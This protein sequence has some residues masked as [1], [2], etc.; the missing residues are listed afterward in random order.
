MGTRDSVPH[1]SLV[2]ATDESQ[3]IY[4]CEFVH[5]MNI[6]NNKSNTNPITDERHGEKRMEH[7]AA[8]RG[9]NK[10]RKPT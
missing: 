5:T 4:V 9:S 3:F 7:I 6:H 10:N 1:S 8:S 2:M